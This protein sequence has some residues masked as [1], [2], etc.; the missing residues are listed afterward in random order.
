[1]KPAY[2]FFKQR[3]II[4]L[5]FITAILFGYSSILLAQAVVEK[6]AEEVVYDKWVSIF[7][8][9]NL[10]GWTIKIRG[11]EVNDNYADTFTVRDGKLVVSYDKYKEFKGKYG[12]IFYKEKLSHYKI[13]VEY[14][15]V[16]TQPKRSP[17]WAIRNNGIMLHCQSPESMTKD[18]GYPVSVEAQMLGGD[19]KNDRTTG[20]ICTPGTN[21]VIDGKLVTKH[22]IPS[23]SKTYHGNQWVTMEVEV[24]GNGT[25]THKVNN[26]LV[27]TYEKPQ[28][29]RK[30]KDAQKLIKD[31]Q[32]MLS[33]GY[34]SLQSESH[35]IEFRKIELMRLK[36]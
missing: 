17:G 2:S 8:G 7:N 21:V 14:R 10:D 20:N 5:L 30:D 25:I 34:I 13:R 33:E 4:S 15:F 9:K 32:L 6:K 23:N 29:D 36:K 22:C 35:P 11:F 24:H 1:M 12:H 16:G 19:G 3:R 26:E 28:Y 31:A 18:Q 27:F